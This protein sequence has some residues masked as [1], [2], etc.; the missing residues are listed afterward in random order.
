MVLAERPNSLQSLP[1]LRRHGLVC[2]R[3]KKGA[4]AF[5]DR[6]HDTEIGYDFGSV[7]PE[8]YLRI[9]EVPLE[10]ASAETK[11]AGPGVVAFLH[12]PNCFFAPCAPIDFGW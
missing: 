1:C 7:G 10:V 5:G 6:T 9:I 11:V 2:P 3:P 4:L 12:E 8:A